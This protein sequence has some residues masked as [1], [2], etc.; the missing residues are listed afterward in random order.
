[1]KFRDKKILVMGLG[2]N[3]GGVGVAKFLA[4]RGARVLVTDLKSKKELVPSLKKLSGFKNI[5]YVLGRH[6]EHDFKNSDIII[7]GPGVPNSSRFLKIAKKYK[8][9]VDTDIGIFF[10]LCP[11]TIIGVTG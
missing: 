6:R 3:E 7:K 2:L 8:K 10:E 9:T 11:A 1:M 4:R 5:K